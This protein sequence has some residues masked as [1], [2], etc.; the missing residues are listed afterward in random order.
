MKKALNCNPMAALLACLC[1]ALAA[2]AQAQ[3]YYTNS[4]TGNWSAAG[5]WTGTPPSAGGAADAYVSLTTPFMAATNDLAGAFTLNGIN[6]TANNSVDVWAAGGSSLLFSGGSPVIVSSGGAGAMSIHSPMTLANNLTIDCSGSGAAI[7]L[8]GT[9]SETTPSSIT[10]NSATANTPYTYFRGTNSS[11]SGGTIVNYASIRP[12]ADNCLGSGVLTWATTGIMS[13]DRSCT[14]TNDIQIGGGYAGVNLQIY[15]ATN[16]VSPET[17]LQ[18]LGRIY[19][20]TPD[21]GGSQL[22]HLNMFGYNATAYWTAPVNIVVSNANYMGN[23]L[24][25]N[26]LRSLKVA[27]AFTNYGAT[28]FNYANGRSTVDVLSNATLATIWSGASGAGFVN[29]VD[30]NV[31]GTMSLTGTRGS[32]LIFREGRLTVKPGGL[33]TNVSNLNLYGTLDVEQR[34]TLVTTGWLPIFGTNGSYWG[35]ANVAGT[36]TAN[37]ATVGAGGGYNGGLLNIYSNGVANI[38]TLEFNSNAV[39]SVAGQ[40]LCNG[41]QPFVLGGT[42][43]LSDGTNAGYARFRSKGGTSVGIMKIIG[44]APGMGTLVLSNASYINGTNLLFGGAGVND[45]NLQLIKDNTGTLVLS[46]SA[47]YYAGDTK[48][49]GGILALGYPSLATNSTITVTNG[50]LQLDFA[51]TNVVK[52]LVFNGTNTV[53]GVHNATTDP[54]ILTGTGSLLALTGA[55]PSYSTTPTNITFSVT[56]SG[57]GGTLNLSWPSSHLGWYVQSNSVAVNNTG[58]WFNVPNSQ[59]GTS[60]SI[61][62]EAV[63][64]NVYFRMRLP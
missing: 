6:A 18:L 49:L 2:G 63:Q 61:P 31:Y 58:A 16:D 64:T 56:G 25:G 43:R 35:N 42:L 20:D 26:A 3:T 30:V 59:N 50:V 54:G 45:N 37:G 33:F 7:Y 9:I 34:G 46:N 19:N 38:G 8:D 44:G 22:H 21:V 10:L 47:N 62:I 15:P 13:P 57:G 53:P 60:L 14:L 51:T 17:T 41:F 1:L 29:S 52:A 55:G 12:G 36:L 24:V 11:Y 27:G 48:V 32:A 5:S 23:L 40:L 39:A 28:I 4:A